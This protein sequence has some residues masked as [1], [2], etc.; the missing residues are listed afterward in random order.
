MLELT[1]EYGE[2][3]QSIGQKYVAKNAQ[4]TFW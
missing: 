1:V 2:S 3:P 4:F